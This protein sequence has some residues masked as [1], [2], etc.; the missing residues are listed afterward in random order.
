MPV[1]SVSGALRSF[2]CVG[3][4]SSGHLEKWVS[5]AGGL[6]GILGVMLVSQAYLGLSGSASLVASMGA[7]AVL[8]FAVP[9]GPLSQPWAVFGG[10]LVSAVIGVA[11]VRLH[12]NPILA[13]ALA[14][15]LAISA[16]HYLRCIHPPGGA[17]A[18][19]AV[20]GGD[21]VHALG[22]HYVLT[23]VLLNVLVI[24]LVAIVFNFPFPWRRY[25]AAWARNRKPSAVPAASKQLAA[26]LS[27]DD[28]ATAAGTMDPARGISENKLD[29]VSSPA[30]GKAESGTLDPA[31]IRVGAYYCNG[32]FSPDWQVRQ[33]IESSATTEHDRDDMITYRVVAVSKRRQTDTVKRE[34]F[35]H[36]A[37]YPVYINENCWQRVDTMPHPAVTGNAT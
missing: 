21:A 28:L 3:A 29:T 26:V 24:L 35:A 15:A 31:D 5:G 9:H 13:S 16:M 18:L 32:E 22:F 19:S 2:A 23:P 30:S 11:C 34:V 7:S 12:A 37:R 27:R 33:V 8:L 4:N 14:V 25:P 1:H 10:H 17:T 6:T 36:W 20:A